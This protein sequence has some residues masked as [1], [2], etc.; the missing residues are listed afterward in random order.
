M[1]RKADEYAVRLKNLVCSNFPQVDFNVA[2]KAPFTIGEL[3][4]Y[5]DNIKNVQDIKEKP[6]LNKQLNSKQSEFEVKTL[7]I[8]AHP[9]RKQQQPKV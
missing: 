7:I 5:N 2:Y 1:H 8:A 4:P 3:F 6:E 9:D